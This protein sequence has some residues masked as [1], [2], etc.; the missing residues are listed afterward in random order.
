MHEV[1]VGHFN[2]AV[3]EK[4]EW[5]FAIYLKFSSAWSHLAYELDLR[6]SRRYLAIETDHCHS[7]RVHQLLS[8]LIFVGQHRANFQLNMKMQS[9]LN[10]TMICGIK[11]GAKQ[12]SLKTPTSGL[13]EGHNLIGA[14]F[15][16]LTLALW[17]G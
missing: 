15:N 13:R 2:F 1:P 6:S 11:G 7:L 17:S 4:N 9:Q 10:R 14:F 5:N 3:L 8:R 16:D 12:T